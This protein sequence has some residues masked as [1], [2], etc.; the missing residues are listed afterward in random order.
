MSLQPGIK[1]RAE[2]TV[3]PGNT[4]AAVGSG[5]LEVFAT[6]AMI[7]LMEKASLESVAPFLG[8]GEST[9][10]TEIHV[11]HDA[12]TPLGETVTAETELIEVDRR[13]LIFRVMARAG[14]EVIGKGTHTRFIVSQEKFMKKFESKKL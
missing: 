12:A 2:V 1:G 5:A 11:S 6:P 8:E 4:A 3:V 9:V 14:D 10:G 13:K 7:A